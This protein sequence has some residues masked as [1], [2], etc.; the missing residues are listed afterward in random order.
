[1]IRGWLLW[2]ASMVWLTQAAVAGTVL[3]KAPA[4]LD[5]G[6]AYVLV[7]LGKLDDALIDAS[8]I[9]SRYDPE[10][11]DVAQ[12]P[13]PSAKNAVVDRVVLG[14]PLIKTGKR[15]LYA[16]ELQPGTWIVEGANDTAF[17]LGA[18]TLKLAPGSVT[19]L[20]Y[21]N[22]YSD[23]ADGAKRD[24]QTTGRLLR[25]AFLGGGL[26]TKAKPEPTPK[27]VDFHPR[28]A[29]D[30]A[31]PA[32]FATPARPPVWEGNVRFPNNL[33]GLVNR[34]GGRKAR[35]QDMAPA[36]PA[37]SPTPDPAPPR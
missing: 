28:G 20:G 14:K 13:D 10:T 23:F 16:L 36:D 1:M 25:S 27:A 35:G 24:V 37:A 3:T 7:E 18:P 19:D 22:V 8:L 32:V 12:V 11:R 5:P 15:R 2:L 21:A 30:V 34:M 31:L 9:L 6:K 26:F 17:S 33:G 29:T 4:Q